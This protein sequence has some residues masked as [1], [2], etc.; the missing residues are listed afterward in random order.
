MLRDEAPY[1]KRREGRREGMSGSM[2]ARLDGILI[3]KLFT[4]LTFIGSAYGME[5][6]SRIFYALVLVCL[7]LTALIYCCFFM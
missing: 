3:L 5:L 1:W 2:N 6:I 7:I 4:Y